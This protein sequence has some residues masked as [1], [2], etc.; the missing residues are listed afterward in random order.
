MREGTQPIP[1]ELEP[2]MFAPGEPCRLNKPLVSL[3]HGWFTQPHVGAPLQ[4]GAERLCHHIEDPLGWAVQKRAETLAQERVRGPDRS[5]V[6][7]VLENQSTVAKRS[8]QR[9]KTWLRV[10]K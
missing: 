9:A 2:F 3:E 8:E 5:R 7:A 6:A 4:P 10:H 1:E